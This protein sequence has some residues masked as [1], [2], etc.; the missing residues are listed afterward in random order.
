MTVSLPETLKDFVDDQVGERG[1]ATSGEYI[2]ELI[3]RDRD[4]QH[5]RG[6]LLEGGA[7]P[8]AAVA[9]ADY[10]DRLRGRVREAGGG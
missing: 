2:R 9:D 5:L 10:F 4:R 7:S 6:L 3:R 8:G 1:Y